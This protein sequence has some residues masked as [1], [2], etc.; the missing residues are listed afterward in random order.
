MLYLTPQ[1][2]INHTGP[3]ANSA[4]SSPF[5]R[6]SYLLISLRLAMLMS[7]SIIASDSLFTSFFTSNSY[8]F[9]CV[10][11]LLF[12]YLLSRERR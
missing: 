2:Y 8:S 10:L 9:S 1:S 4:S 7:F 6:L 3:R 12:F 11:L 5:R